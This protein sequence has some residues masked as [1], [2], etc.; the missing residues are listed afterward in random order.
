[1][2]EHSGA[3]QASTFPR[4]FRHMTQYNETRQINF[5][6]KAIQNNNT[7]NKRRIMT[8]G[9]ITVS[10]IPEQLHSAMDKLQRIGQN[11]G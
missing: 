11:L 10:M 1:M 8:V 2:F 9:K 4:L 7:K 5:Q 6:H 3:Y